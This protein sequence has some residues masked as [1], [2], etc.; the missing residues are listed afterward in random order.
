MYISK[1]DC[2]GL[3]HLLIKDACIEAGSST[4]Q[5]T[6]STQLLIKETDFT[7]TSSR[8]GQNGYV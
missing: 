4:K 8:I 5:S 7:H 2:L 1:N 3:V 6:I